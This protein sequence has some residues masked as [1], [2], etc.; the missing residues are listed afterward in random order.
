MEAWLG[1]PGGSNAARLEPGLA[2]NQPCFWD[3]GLV[4]PK[5]NKSILLHFEERRLF[6]QRPL[7]REH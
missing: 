7:F 4:I 6:K 1:N 3:I 2:R 5:R